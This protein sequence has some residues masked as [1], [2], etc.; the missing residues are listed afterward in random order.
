MGSKCLQYKLHP[1]G[2]YCS[3]SVQLTAF[4]PDRFVADNMMVAAYRNIQ[5]IPEDIPACIDIVVAVD[6]ILNNMHIEH[7]T[8]LR[9]SRI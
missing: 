2:M 4:L 6:L 3:R 9:K 8:K 7:I 1:E 5:N